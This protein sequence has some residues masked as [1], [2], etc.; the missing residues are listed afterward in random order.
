MARLV[1]GF[2]FFVSLLCA[3]DVVQL[4][5]KIYFE[6]NSPV[7]S[8]EARQYL[9][10]LAPYLKQQRDLK[11]SSFDISG[12]TDS[13]GEEKANRTLSRDRACAVKEYLVGRHKI[14]A[15]RLRCVGHGALLP[16]A[17]NSLAVGQK[18][19]RRVVIS[20]KKEFSDSDFNIEYRYDKLGRLKTAR[21]SNGHEI[22]FEYDAMGNI[23]KRVDTNR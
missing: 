3:Q 20:K 6:K 19:N 23:L 14:A 18:L 4:E 5:K 21:Y 9:D 22:A 16:I 12:H 13:S 11:Q 2:L 10:K 15:S 1:T 17:D 7:L 8:K